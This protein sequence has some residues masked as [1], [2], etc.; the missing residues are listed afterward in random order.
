MKALLQLPIRLYRWLISPMLGTNCRYHPSCSAY[1]LEAIEKHGA[2]RGSW[3]SLRRVCRCHP[4]GGDGY[5]PVPG[6]H[7]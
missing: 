6:G 3:L 1:A 7:C 5:D 2:A 4:W